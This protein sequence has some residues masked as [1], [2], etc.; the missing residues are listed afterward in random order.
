MA[1]VN[2]LMDRINAEFSAAELQQKQ[3]QAERVE[4]YHG[5]Q[6][7][8]EQF[9]HTLVRL[10]DIWNPRLETLAK[11]FAEQVEVKPSIEPAK[12]SGTF[13]FKSP[14]AHIK[15]RFAAAPD[16][17]VKNVVFTYDLEILPILMKFDSHS[18]LT[19]P[20]DKVDEKKL[21]DWF[22]DRIVD[23][24]KTYLTLHENQYYLKDHLV[25]DPIAKVKFPKYA[26]GATLDV[27]GK[28]YYFIDE[29][30][31]RDFEKKSS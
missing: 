27:K 20:I 24:V 6:Q 18:E 21:G 4:A 26:A 2:K 11:K 15:L 3:L 10:K 5:R 31:R 19:M 28:T 14:L 29:A 13:A 23:F 9:E 30:T 1:D 16:G 8:L 12:R 22:D 25:E 17:D 7:R